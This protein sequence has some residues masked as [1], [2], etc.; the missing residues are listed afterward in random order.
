MNARHTARGE[1]VRNPE[2]GMR[3][4][5][6]HLP[7]SAFRI[8][9]R[10][11]LVSATMLSSACSWFTDFKRQPKIDPWE[12]VGDSMTPARGQPQGSVAI[13]GTAM[14]GYQVSYQP[15]P[16]TVDSL[17]PVP[18]PTPPSPA[19][20]ANGR[21]YFQINCAVCHGDKAMGDGPAT[22]F[23]M[24]PM[25]LTTDVTRN[26]TDGYIFG[27]MR[28]GRG[29]M[30]PYNRIEEADRWD[31]VN[32]LRGLQGKLALQ[33]DIGPVA[34]PGVTGD[35]LPGPTPIGPT[36]PAPYFH[37]PRARLDEMRGT[38]VTA[39]PSAPRDDEDETR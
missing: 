35:A 28:N 22:K 31:V 29:L 7:H 10:L 38:P 39:P 32:Y 33:V 37:A 6:G 14:A 2:S 24:V 34:A 36:R 9:L 18:N 12:T 5:P 19:S 1:G 8:P 15:L 20:L 16:G 30:P 11:L 26:R 23:G 17:S 13:T 21:K 25:P 3:N 4:N 27:M